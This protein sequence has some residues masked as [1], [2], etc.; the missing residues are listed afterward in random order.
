MLPLSAL[1]AGGVFLRRY[2]QQTSASN[3]VF[4]VVVGNLTV[5]GNGKTP[6]VIA[7][8]EALQARGLRVGV[9]SRGYGRRSRHDILLQPQHHADEV[10]DEALLIAR[11]CRVPVAVAVKRQQALALLLQHHDLDLVLSDDGL[12]HYRLP[13]DY[14]IVVAAGDLGWGNGF[15]L[16]AGCLRE[17][18][19]RLQTVN[20]LIYTPPQPHKP[21][22]LPAYCL[23]RTPYLYRLEDGKACDWEDAQGLNQ[24]A[25][26]TIARPERF[27]SLLRAHIA[28]EALQAY[29]D[30]APITPDM[31]DFARGKRLFIT[32][33]DA[34][35]IENSPAAETIVVAE[36][37]HLDA[38]LLDDIINKKNQTKK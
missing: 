7:L 16:P 26:T 35:K 11:R 24:V 32:E 2:L 30:H 28:L 10:G 4:T 38:A 17:P 18:W 9:I 8:C 12:Q 19:K 25:L 37:L 33:K 20:A 1:F 34:V 31:L 23:Q 5:G 15:L 36:A 3:P 29:P 6:A 13:R 14:E 21:E 27:F 22:A